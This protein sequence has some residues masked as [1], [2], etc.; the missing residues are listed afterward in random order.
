M[1]GGDGKLDMV[2]NFF[3]RSSA[4]AATRELLA[5]ATEVSLRLLR[6]N[7]AVRTT[8][9]VDG[10]ASPCREMAERCQALGVEHLHGG[11]ELGF[12]EAYNLGWRS[13]DGELVGLMANDVLPLPLESVQVLLE[14]VRQPDVGCVFPYLISNR[15]AWDETQRPSFLHRGRISCEPASMTVNLN[16]FKREV[17]ERIGGLDPNYLVGFESPILLI[18]IRTLGYRAVMVGG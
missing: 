7:P 1:G 11:R 12:A 3:C 13:L 14:W 16:L 17:L 5:A 6:R 8:L 9:L 2:V 18:K 10:S 15:A 4:D